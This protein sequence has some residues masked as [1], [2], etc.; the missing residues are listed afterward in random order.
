VSIPRVKLGDFV[1]VLCTSVVILSHKQK[2]YQLQG[3]RVVVGGGSNPGIIPMYNFFVLVLSTQVSIPRVKLGDFAWVLCTSVVILSHK[4]TSYQFQGSRVDPC[5]S[6][7]FCA[8]WRCR[9]TSYIV[10]PLD[11]HT[12]NSH[13]FLRAPSNSQRSKRYRSK[14]EEKTWTVY[15]RNKETWR[16]QMMG[17]VLAGSVLG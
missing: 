6:W 16:C 7:R 12:S 15:K 3:S 9:C 1:W 11:G 17:V 8:T 5:V 10:V 13:I 4:Q 2:S 14:K